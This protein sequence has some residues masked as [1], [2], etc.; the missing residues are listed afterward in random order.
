LTGYAA[1]DFSI[2]VLASMPGAKWVDLRSC[3]VPIPG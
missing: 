1:L 2:E 3:R